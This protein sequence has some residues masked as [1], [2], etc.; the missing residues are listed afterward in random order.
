L[1][2]SD[3]AYPRFKNRPSETELERFYIPTEIER[4]FCG[5]YTRSTTTRLGFVLLLKTYQRLGYFVTS[6]QIPSAIIEHIAA[7]LDWICAHR[8]FH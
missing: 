8:I 6:D 5:A 7:A 3:T 2:P 4:T 1:Q